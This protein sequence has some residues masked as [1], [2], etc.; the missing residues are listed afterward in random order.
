MEEVEVA[1]VED[2]QSV[3]GQ[4]PLL[5]LLILQLPLLPELLLR[6]P[7]EPQTLLPW[8]QPLRLSPQY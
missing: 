3:L 7:Q 2:R 8:L 5:L 1:G 4:V 6:L